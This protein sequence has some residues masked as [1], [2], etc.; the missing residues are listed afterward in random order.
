[1]RLLLLV[2]L[3]L[4][5]WRLASPRQHLHTWHGWQRHSR[6]VCKVF[7]CSLNVRHVERYV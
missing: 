6:H 1:M 7:S 5:V 3:L 2:V 4:A